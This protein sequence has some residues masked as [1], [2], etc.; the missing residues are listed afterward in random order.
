MK[1]I[2]N[3]IVDEACSKC[4][5]AENTDHMIL[6]CCYYSEKIWSSFQQLLNKAERRLH[7]KEQAKRVDPDCNWNRH[8][9]NMRCLGPKPEICQISG[10]PPNMQRMTEIFYRLGSTLAAV[11]RFYTIRVAG[12]GIIFEYVT[13][14]SICDNI[15]Q[16]SK[17][18]RPLM[19]R[20]KTGGTPP[21][22]KNT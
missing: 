1:D 16:L 4:G 9:L 7:I 21:P 18:I 22:K 5:E 11:H 15:Q 20:C 12:F 14:T 10:N 6:E 17:S 19:A 13:F 8:P 2:N 3:I